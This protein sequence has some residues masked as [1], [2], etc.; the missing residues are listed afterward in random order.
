MFLR[1]TVGRNNGKETNVTASN[2]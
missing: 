2:L 1:L